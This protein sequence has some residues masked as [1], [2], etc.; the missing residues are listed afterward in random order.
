MTTPSTPD[1]RTRARRLL[2]EFLD[3]S[4]GSREEF[5]AWVLQHA[6]LEDLLQAEYDGFEL[7]LAKVE[8]AVPGPE[9]A[10]AEREARAS[11][12]P[13][14][15]V[16][17][18]PQ[19]EEETRRHLQSR[20]GLALLIAS[21]GLLVI[22]L[23]M[24]LVIDMNEGRGLV[25]AI[26]TLA[27]SLKGAPLLV[28]TGAALGTFG[29]LRARRLSQ[30]ALSWVDGVFLQ[31]S[32]ALV[33]FP[34]AMVLV[35]EG[36]KTIVY[37]QR[38]AILLH[39]VFLRAILIPSTAWR[40]FLLSLPAP[41]VTLAVD[42]GLGIPDDASSAE[43]A[44]LLRSTMIGHTLLFTSVVVAAIASKV[45]LSL[46]R[47]T[48]EATN[49]GL[50]ELEERIG[51]GGMGEVYRATHSLLK[52]PTAIKFMNPAIASPANLQR[53]EQEVRLTARL[54]HPNIVLIYDYGYTAQGVF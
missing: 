16:F 17:A 40:T 38:F 3:R 10:A 37:P 18:R 29:L 20:L 12:A 5:E 35:D 25:D 50:Y 49:L 36:M 32:F 14:Q 28:T 51:A 22:C 8:A 53:F 15:A 45:N 39:I 26:S 46:R 11:P 7:A 6:E 4:D 41:L 34:V 30:R 19:F 21:A 2:K 24:A 9:A 27:G 43:Q 44:E 31:V 42:V 54:T 47:R 33:W 48:W 13:R 1:R 23:E 52:R